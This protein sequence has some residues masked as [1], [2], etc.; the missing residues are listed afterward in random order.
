MK[1]LARVLFVLAAALLFSSALNDA[2]AAAAL[3]P[4]DFAY[5]RPISLPGDGA[6]Y[7]LAIPREVYGAV[8]RD[9][10]NDIRIFNSA[11]AVV[12]HAL[13]LPKNKNGI[14]EV[15]HA[16]PFF[17]LYMDNT[18]GIKDG[19]S[20][21]IE[22]GKDGAIINVEESDATSGKDRKLSGYIIDASR[23]AGQVDELDIAWKEEADN[24]VTTVS[25]ESSSD[26]THWSMPVPRATLTRMRF[27][28][29]EIS[30]KRILLPTSPDRY[31]RLSWP[32]GAQG[33][34]VEKILGVQW[35]GEPEREPVWIAFKGKPGKDDTKLGESKT[36][37]TAYEY[38]SAARM[39]V[40]RIRLRF[41]EKNTL[42]N[43]RLLSRP[44]PETNWRFRQSGIFYDLRF[45]DVALVQDTVSIGQTA[46]RYWRVEMDGGAAPDPANDD[47]NIPVLELGWLPHELLFVARGKG[48]FMLAYGSARLKEAD[49]N[50][51]QAGLLYQ[52]I[53]ANE[54]AL[55][56]K[57]ALMPKIV[58]GGPDLLLPEPPP[59]P[60]RK[61]LLWG[62]LVMGVGIIARMALSLGKGINKE[63][64]ES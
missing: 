54:D 38:D 15:V 23:Q 24:F 12:P 37:I 25:V 10:L 13:R 7:R 47:A 29:H 45:D 19:L 14:A 50:Q 56:K 49:L 18:G 26:L 61:W 64:K 52:V 44:D 46:D 11:N 1:I 21:R 27:N 5:G 40:D 42:V 16:L 48:P 39:T 59:L 28:G 36:G 22:Q 4:A 58:L 20:V 60:W 63:E 57:A 9:D 51:S 17:P 33:V 53:G 8:T 2:G 30:R 3:Q 6:V 31:L 62:V 34:A 55:L 32:G 41:A 35:S 43:V